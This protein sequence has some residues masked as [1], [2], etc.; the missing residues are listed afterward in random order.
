MN[1]F[2]MEKGNLLIYKIIKTRPKNYYK[3]G[4]KIVQ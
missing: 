1:S 4:K 2:G 3:N